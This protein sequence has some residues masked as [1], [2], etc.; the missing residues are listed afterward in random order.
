M[1]EWDIAEPRADALIES[2]RAFGYTPE[3]AIADIVDNSISAGAKTIRIDM[4]WAGRDS[5]VSIVDDGK[6][7]TEGD[8]YVAMRPGSMSPL[9]ARSK[10]DLGRF[11][12]GLKTAS[13]SQARE[14]TVSS[15]TP[16]GTAIR[17]WDLDTVAK[18]GEWRLLRTGPLAESVDLQ[19]LRPC[20][21]VVTW[22]KCDRLVGDVD[23]GD[24]KAHDRFLG[25]IRRVKHHLE[26]TFHRFLVGRGRLSMSLNGQPLAAWDPFLTDHPATQLLFSEELPFQGELVKVKAYVLPHRSKLSPAEV[27]RGHGAMG[28]NQQQGFY[29][30]RSN[31]LLVQGDW[32]GLGLTKDEHTKLARI[33]IDFPASL[34]HA[35]QVDVKK[36]AARTPGPLVTELFRIAKVA[37]SRA[38]EV[39]RFR[40]KIMASKSSQPFIVA[41][42]QYTDRAGEIRYRVNRSH[43]VIVAL[44]DAN[45]GRKNDI[46]KALRFIE[47]TVPTTLIGVSIADSLDHQ[48]TPFGGATKDLKPIIKFVFADLIKDGYSADEALNQI[49][50]IEP[51]AQFPQVVQALRESQK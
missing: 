29:L 14:L 50:V 8:L 4:I 39:Y 45:A 46:E 41:W 49:A 40:G 37:R 34:D 2:L 20:G 28:W 51:F 5:I 35:W 27:E 15:R 1:S 10:G 6:G 42:E 36:S 22:T 17:R 11:G 13:F 25:L 3:A 7:M 12:L 38:E 43:P 16:A 48:P 24:S 30:Y 33:A 26:A 21:T 31:R 19:P 18:T 47:E 9:D 32:L 23:A 44:M